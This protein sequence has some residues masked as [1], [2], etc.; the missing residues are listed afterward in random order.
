MRLKKFNFLSLRDTETRHESRPALRG[1]PSRMSMEHTGKFKAFS[2][3]ELSIV[4]LIVGLLVAGISGSKKLINKSK[5]AAARTLSQSS[6]VASIKNLI[7]WLDAAKE[8]S[9]INSSS[10]RAISDGD[11]VQSWIDGNQELNKYLIFSTSTATTYPIYRKTSFNG[12]PT[13]EFDGSNDFL[14]TPNTSRISQP[15]NFSIFIVFAPLAGNASDTRVSILSKSG[16]STSNPAYQI[17]FDSSNM[18]P[19]VVVTSDSTTQISYSNSSNTLKKNVPTI[20]TVT[21]NSITT[22]SGL[23]A[24]IN[25][26]TSAFQ[27]GSSSALS[28][29]IDNSQPLDIARYVDK[30]GSNANRFCKCYISEIIMYDRV[31]DDEELS[32]ITKYLGRKWGISIS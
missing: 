3:V 9:F 6:E 1:T 17:A 26:A 24:Y 5:L 32:A 20:L 22:A 11:Y 14:S 30:S 25:G 15:N 27:L 10:S 16:S 28:S 8:N 2:L 21:H 31:L 4:I 19:S 23:K 12:L 13:V 7:F 29:I 18:N